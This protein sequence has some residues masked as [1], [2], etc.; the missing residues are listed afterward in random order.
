M[1]DEK[2][3]FDD[4]KAE[5]LF[6]S[7]F[8][9]LIA[10]LL[11]KFP[12]LHITQNIIY[13]PFNLIHQIGHFFAVSILLPM[14]DPAFEINPIKDCICSNTIRIEELPPNWNSVY[15]LLA[16]TV[17]IIFFTTLI[18]FKFRKNTSI[19]WGINQRFLLFGLIYNL[20][21]LF[22]ILPSMLGSTN[23]GYAVTVILLRMGFST[24]P[25]VYIS[26]L[27][28]SLA[29]ILI[30]ISYYCLGSCIYYV[31][32]IPTTKLQRQSQALMKSYRI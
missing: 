9:V 19:T 13:L 10:F 28:A 7:V 21:N 14:I 31:I 5:L 1:N 27:F 16:G 32:T 22:P 26:I 15:M 29:V 2:L 25:L 11:Q 23:D 3:L 12:I 24:Y 8:A 17:V 30:L 6:S 4:Q 18:L 20:T